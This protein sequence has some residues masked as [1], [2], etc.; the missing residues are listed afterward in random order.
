M[1]IPSGDSWVAPKQLFVKDRLDLVVKWRF[2]RHLVEGGDVDA[3]RV[4][5]W[6]IQQRT[7]GIEPGSTKRTV[8]DYV[9]AC[10]ALL[11]SMSVHGFDPLHPVRVGC[12]GRLKGGA[13]RTACARYLGIDI[14][15][16]RLPTP[17]RAA[18]WG[19]A[20][21]ACHGMAAAAVAGLERERERLVHG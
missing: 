19:H 14:A 18:P 17:S 16:Q 12:D 9:D 8:E 11:A 6:H 15:V 5:R 7:G 1:S 2:F 20:W 21:F 13:H 10:R 3:E 4:Y